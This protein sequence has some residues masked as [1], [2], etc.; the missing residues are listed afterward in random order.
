[1]KFPIAANDAVSKAEGLKVESSEG[2]MPDCMKC[3]SIASMPSSSIADCPR[4]RGARMN[5]RAAETRTMSN[6]LDR[7]TKNE[8]STD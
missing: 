4:M 5:G 2:T 3:A 7:V 1:M 6:G 8:C